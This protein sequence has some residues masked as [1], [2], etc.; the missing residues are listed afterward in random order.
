MSTLRI[1]YLAITQLAENP[2]NART[3]SKKQIRQIAD[4]IRAFGFTNPILID[5]ANMVLAGHGRLAAARLLCMQQVPCVRI[6]QL[7]SAQKRAYALTDN[8]LALNAGWDEEIL[9]QELKELLAIDLD[10]D[11]GI[12]GFCIAEADSLIEGLAFVKH[13]EFA[14][15]SGEMSQGEFT[16]FLQTAFANFRKYS[17]DGSI[18][19]ICMDWRHMVEIL[20]AGGAVYDELKN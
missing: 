13:R 9:G 5:S 3:H 11:I 1:T 12:T 14:M 15:A 18:H 17:V 8:K 4:S 16:A 2:R 20:T 10:F 7:T 6:D 19:F